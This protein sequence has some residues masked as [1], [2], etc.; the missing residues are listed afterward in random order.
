MWRNGQFALATHFHARYAFV[1][2]AN[3]FAATQMKAERIVAVMAGV[4][5]LAVFQAAC[6]MHNNIL[7]CVG[8]SA[9]ALGQVFNYQFW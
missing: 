4:E 2:T 8:D 7:A 3:H 6:V 1:P 9:I 5:F